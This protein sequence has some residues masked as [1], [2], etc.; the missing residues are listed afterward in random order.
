MSPVEEVRAALAASTQSTNPE[1]ATIY[2]AA[3]RI[4]LNRERKE[5][6][7]LETVIAAREAALVRLIGGDVRQLTIPGST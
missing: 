4:V 5:L 6:D 1:L 3:A 7:S 2:L